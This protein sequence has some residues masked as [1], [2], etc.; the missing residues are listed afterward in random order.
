MEQPK[1]VMSSTLS[2]VKVDG[3]TALTTSLI[4]VENSRIPD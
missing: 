4:A 3:S 2:D 1:N